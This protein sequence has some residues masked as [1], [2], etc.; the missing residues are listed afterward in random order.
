[1][2]RSVVVFV[3]SLSVEILERLVGVRIASG[4]ASN[5][6]HVGCRGIVGVLI[7]AALVARRYFGD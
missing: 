1:M 3:A 6:V 2:Q 7:V 5:G 4:V